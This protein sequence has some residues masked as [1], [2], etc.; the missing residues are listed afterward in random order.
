MHNLHIV[1]ADLWCYNT[2]QYDIRLLWV[3]RMQLNTR[4][5]IHNTNQAELNCQYE[6]LY[7]MRWMKLLSYSLLIFGIS[8]LLWRLGLRWYGV[9]ASIVSKGA[10][11]WFGWC[12]ILRNNAS[13]AASKI[14]VISVKPG[15]QKPWRM[16]VARKHLVLYICGKAWPGLWGIIKFGCRRSL[17]AQAEASMPASWN[18]FAIN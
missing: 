16:R 4:D 17:R 1:I 14:S 8:C 12:R 7:N 15:G 10:S 6:S 5:T 18:Q 9:W 13:S 2:I 3:D 11:R